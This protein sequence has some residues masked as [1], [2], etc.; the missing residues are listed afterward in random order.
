MDF[1]RPLL[2]FKTRLTLL[3][4]IM[5]GIASCRENG[6]RPMESLAGEHDS[7]AIKGA[8]KKVIVYPYWVTS[9]QFAGYYVG[10]EKGIFEK[11]GID[12]EILEYKPFISTSEIIRSGQADFAVTWLVNALQMRDQGIRIINIAQFSTRS[13]L[14]LV[15]KKSSGILTPADMNGKRAGIW[16]GYELQPRTFF[17]KYGLNV[18]IIPIGNTNNLFLQDGV[19]I[20]N[21]NWFD[22]YHTIINSGIDTNE[23]VTF[24][25][26]KHGLNFLEDGIYCLEEKL[27][28]DPEICVRFVKATMESW[29][30]AMTHPD[31][32][33]GI[34]LKHLRMQKMIANRSHQLWMI[35]RYKDLYLPG[36]DSVMNTDL[37]E[38]LY[39]FHSRVLLD[40]HLIGHAIPYRDFYRPYT[41]LTGQGTQN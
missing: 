20:T 1:F 8:P 30:Y 14:M 4:L 10:R 19:E 32:S 16:E 18:D 33:V 13:S 29:I 6:N 2:L 40:N 35:R 5:A 11:Y 41:G 37:P 25:F 28:S 17:S 15:A 21:A 26:E 23:L 38:G 22:E 7:A 31:E 36:S 39:N 27:S 3:L 12:L 34:I 24:F 9:A